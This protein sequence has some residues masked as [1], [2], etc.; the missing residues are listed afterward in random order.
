MYFYQQVGRKIN[1][2]SFTNPNE[3]EVVVAEADGFTED[4]VGQIVTLLNKVYM[5][6]Q[7]MGE[8]NIKYRVKETLGL[9]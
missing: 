5:T 7:V 1:Q 6:G 2:R 4:Q 8:R 9:L 3:Y